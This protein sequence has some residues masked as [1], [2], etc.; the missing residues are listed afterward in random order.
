[1]HNRKAAVASA[2]QHQIGQPCRSMAATGN[3]HQHSQHAAAMAKSPA[4]SPQSYIGDARRNK[5]HNANGRRDG[6]DHQVEHKD[7]PNWMGSMPSAMAAGTRIGIRISIAANAS[8]KQP[9]INNSTLTSRGTS[10]ACRQA[11]NLRAQRL[12]Q[13]ADRQAPAERCCRHHHH[14]STTP[15]GSTVSATSCGNCRKSKSR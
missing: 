7:Q 3:G 1:M 2:A 10:A 4:T 6:A 11:D 5:Q 12:R 8:M 9:T 13:T 14:A 15:V